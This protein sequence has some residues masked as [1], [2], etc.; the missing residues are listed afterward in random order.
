MKKPKVYFHSNGPSGNAY[1][2]LALVREALRKEHRIN[3][4]NELRDK[5]LS[6][7]IDYRE[8]LRL[9]REKVD[10]VDLDGEY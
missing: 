9:I 8:V 5:V 4:Y 7:E 10:L 6:G 3:D 1:H 2:V